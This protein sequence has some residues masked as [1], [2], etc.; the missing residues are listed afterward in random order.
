[1]GKPNSRGVSRTR[2]LTKAAAAKYRK[3]R[4]RVMAEIPP[5][6]PAPLKVAMAKLRAMR[7]AKGVSRSELAARTDITRGN[8]ARLESQK[9]AT[10]QTLQRYAEGLECQLALPPQDATTSS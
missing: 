1:M 5:A 7:Q 9:N 4:Q 10:L 3:I 2:R 6:Q 8:L